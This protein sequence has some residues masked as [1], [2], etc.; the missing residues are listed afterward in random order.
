[1]ESLTRKSKI[2]GKAHSPSG[3][4]GSMLPQTAINYP[5][6]HTLYKGAIN[7]TKKR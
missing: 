2:K 6:S 7:A 3:N 1:M 4:K 5:G